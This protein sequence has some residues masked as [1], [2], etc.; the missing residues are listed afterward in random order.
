LFVGLLTD[1]SNPGTPLNEPSEVVAEILVGGLAQAISAWL[2]GDVVLTQ[3]QFVDAC[4]QVFLDA[5]ARP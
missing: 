3:E 1:E 2:D 4:T 5:L